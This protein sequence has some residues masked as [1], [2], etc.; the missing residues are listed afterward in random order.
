[1]P[2][3]PETASRFALDHAGLMGW[4]RESDP[5]T[6][7]AL[8]AEAD[9]VRRLH[10]GDDVHL[11]G[12]IEASSHCIR[13][14][15]YCGLRAASEGLD[16]Y[17]MDAAEI[18]ACAQ[19]A[20]R[21]GYG[22][23][24][25]QAGEDPGLSQAFIADVVRAI[26][27]HTTLAITLSLGERSDADLLAWREAGADRYLLR[28]ETSDP[29][30]YRRIHPSLPGVPSDRFAQL[31]RMRA[32]GYEIGTGVMVGIPGQT[33]DTLAA[34]ILRFRDFD[35][36]MIG[37]G[38]FLP[39]PRTP[40]GSP[41]AA[42][43]LAPP[44][45]QVPNNELTTLKVVALTR[46]VCPQAN[47]PST[48]ALA[49]LDRAQGRE[50][51]LM[52]GANVVMPNV[53]PV[54]YRVRYEIYPGKACIHETAAACQGCLAGRIHA[55]GRRVGKGPGGRQRPASDFFVASDNHH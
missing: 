14:C 17:R 54:A 36:D 45:Q 24:V 28:F 39:S 11:R 4:L 10:V 2:S 22:S 33:W 29:E 37:V 5:K 27:R 46:L 31:D 6:L 35:M 51:A 44:D 7:E 42:A 23:V 18:L 53:T 15:L 41:E 50:L 30:L 49:T 47:L 52:R 55:L 34:D 32:M 12:L 9:L 38:P 43:L 1:M 20:V 3:A 25:I 40:L 8:W 13:Q 26:K 48:T 21:L 16:R 19:E